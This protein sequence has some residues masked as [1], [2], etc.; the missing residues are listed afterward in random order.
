MFF[1]KRLEFDYIVL[2]GYFREVN[3]FLV[4]LCVKI[5]FFIKN[6]GNT[7][8]HTCGKVFACFADNNN[9][10]AC[11]IFTAVVADTLNN[12]CCA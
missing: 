10:T 3:H 5:S 2:F 12:C 8:G 7:A 11:H 9:P 4:K 6:I 1:N